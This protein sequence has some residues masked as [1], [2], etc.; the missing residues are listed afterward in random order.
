[1]DLVCYWLIIRSHHLLTT[2]H[3]IQH[4]RSV[5]CE[6]VVRGNGSFFVLP[7]DSYMDSQR[8]MC[9]FACYGYGDCISHFIVTIHC[10]HIMPILSAKTIFVYWTILIRCK[11]SAS[12]SLGF[13]CHNLVETY[14]C[15]FSSTVNRCA[16]MR[17]YRCFSDERN[18]RI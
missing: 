5:V 16:R 11:Q 9:C 10:F 8:S 18:N 7:S 15:E 12:C 17:T 6:S 4:S 13:Q 1:M 2:F 14:L 3:L